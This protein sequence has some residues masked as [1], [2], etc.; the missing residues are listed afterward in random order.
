MDIVFLP[1]EMRAQNKNLIATWKIKVM[2]LAHLTLWTE[3]YINY[4]NL[5]VNHIDKIAQWAKTHI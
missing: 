3:R 5:E 4:T 2:I 1:H